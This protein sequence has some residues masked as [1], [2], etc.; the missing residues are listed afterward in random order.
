MAVVIRNSQQ[1]LSLEDIFNSTQTVVIMMSTVAKWTNG[2]LY[3]GARFLY[4]VDVYKVAFTEFN[5]HMMIWIE[6]TYVPILDKM[7]R[8]CVLEKS[9]KEEMA[10]SMCENER[11]LG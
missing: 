9:V 3:T 8:K 2:K 10:K 4:A 5:S 11:L 1:L 7:C 6:F